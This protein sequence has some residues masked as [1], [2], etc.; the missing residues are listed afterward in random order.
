[1]Y[2]IELKAHVLNKETILN[3]LNKIAQYK[4]FVDR[5]DIYYTKPIETQGSLNH[6]TVRI[7]KETTIL[8]EKEHISYLLTYKKKEI[9]TGAQTVCEVNDE[10]E[11]CISDP[12]AL[13]NLFIDTGFTESLRK[14]K[15]VDDWILETPYGNATLE[16]CTVPPLGH[17]IEIEII[18]ASNET[19]HTLKVKEELEKI[20]EK[21]GISKKNI[22]P[23][24]YREMLQNVQ[25]NKS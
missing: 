21:T 5:Q 10:K 16:L 4:G 15:L 8:N 14:H 24:Y 6:I 13:T 9:L 25:S 11:C 17:F 1:M 12:E 18:S 22:E 3:T 2:E 20:L 23:R 7:R 19:E